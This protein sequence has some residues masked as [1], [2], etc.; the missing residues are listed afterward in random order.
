MLISTVSTRNDTHVNECTHAH[1]DKEGYNSRMLPYDASEGS[2]LIERDGRLY[3]TRLDEEK[4][5][6]ACIIK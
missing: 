5:I 6:E 3:L 2:T 1:V 4:G